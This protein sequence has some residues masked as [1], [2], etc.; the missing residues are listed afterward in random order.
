MTNAKIDALYLFEHYK[1]SGAGLA[2]TLYQ[3][4]VKRNGLKVWEAQALKREFSKLLKAAN[5]E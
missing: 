3:R 2:D 5:N 1:Q 4:I